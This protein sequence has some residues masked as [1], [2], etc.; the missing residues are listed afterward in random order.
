MFAGMA[1]GPTIGSLLIRA[2]ETIISV[3]YLTTSVHLIYAV[4]I[5]LVLPEPLSQSRMKDSQRRYSQELRENA[6]TTQGGSIA[7]KLRA[8]QLFKFLTPLG[9]FMPTFVDS[10]RN[11]LKRQ[12]RDWSLALLAIAY[13]FTISII[14]RRPPRCAAH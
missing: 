1:F 6:E 3:F 2:T 4:L 11:P 10:G 9:I 8:K 12:E 7:W 13:G 14:V 5:F